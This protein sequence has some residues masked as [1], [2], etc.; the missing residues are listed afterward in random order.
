MARKSIIKPLRS[1]RAAP[2]RRQSVTS[3]I[4]SMNR[5]N[6]LMRGNQAARIQA[7]YRRH[8]QRRPIVTSGGRFYSRNYYSR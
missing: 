5:L 2:R 8:A 7:A 4:G 3:Y 1:I 6:N